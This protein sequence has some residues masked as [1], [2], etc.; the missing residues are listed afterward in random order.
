LSAPSSFFLLLHLSSRLRLAKVG[1]GSHN[2]PGNRPTP[3]RCPL[4]P[5]SH[6]ARSPG[7]CATATPCKGEFCLHGTDALLFRNRRRAPGS[8]HALTGLPGYRPGCFPRQWTLLSSQTDQQLILLSLSSYE[9]SLLLPRP[10][11]AIVNHWPH[12]TRR[13]DLTENTMPTPAEKVL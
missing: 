3:A 2:L 6:V 7:C 12:R 11:L 13:L 5:S 8:H 10:D 9:V 4:D 1:I